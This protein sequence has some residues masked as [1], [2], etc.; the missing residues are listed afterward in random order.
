MAGA[1]GRDRRARASEHVAGARVDHC[2]RSL[3]V[4]PRILTLRIFEPRVV[5]VVGGPRVLNELLC[6]DLQ[7]RV[8]RDLHVATRGDVEV[9][10]QGVLSTAAVVLDEAHT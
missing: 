1:R 10:P 6:D 3:D 2:Q 5:S 4:V 9:A 8:D 7:A